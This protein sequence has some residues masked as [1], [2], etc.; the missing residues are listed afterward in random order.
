MKM[1]NT[2]NV[3]IFILFTI[4]LFHFVEKN[5]YIFLIFFA[6]NGGSILCKTALKQYFYF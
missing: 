3:P 5:I 2:K 6:S 1:F 4:T